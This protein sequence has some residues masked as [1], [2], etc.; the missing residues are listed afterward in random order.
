MVVYLLIYAFIHA[1]YFAPKL[2][3]INRGHMQWKQKTVL[4]S[5]PTSVASL[6]SAETWEVRDW[7]LYA[8]LGSVRWQRSDGVHHPAA[9]HVQRSVSIRTRR[10]IR[11]LECLGAA[12]KHPIHSG[13][14]KQ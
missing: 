3:I 11:W 12:L 8:A 13:N 7:A 9:V 2:P 14:K 4:Q 5:T 6:Y 10:G 1:R